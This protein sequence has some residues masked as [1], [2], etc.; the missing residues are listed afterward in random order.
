MRLIYE[1]NIENMDFLEIILSEVDMS[2][3]A[4][5]GASKDFKEGLSGERP[6]NVFVRTDVDE[7]GTCHSKVKRNRNFC[8]PNTLKSLK[9]LLNTQP[10]Q[11][12]SDCPS[13]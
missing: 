8:M 9:N 3:L 1:K 11:P 2:H 6:L 12:I 7:D 10:S 5:R 13:M 4:R